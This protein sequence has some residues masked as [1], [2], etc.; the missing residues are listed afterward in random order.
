MRPSA[1]IL[2]S[3]TTVLSACVHRENHSPRPTITDAEKASLE[4]RVDCSTAQQDIAT[5]EEEKA[6]IGRRALAGVRSVIP[7]SAAAG[8]LMGDFPDRVEVATGTYN[9]AL[10]NKIREIQSVCGITDSAPS[11]S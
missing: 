8:I 11:E 3:L 4:K 6:S 1:V 5:L 10:E 7:F 2:F 9:E